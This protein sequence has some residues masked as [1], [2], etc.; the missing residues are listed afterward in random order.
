M[1][2]VTLVG[3]GPGHPDYLTLRGLR[4][5]DAADVI[6][7]D[8]LIDDSFKTLFPASAELFFV[9]K[10]CGQHYQTQEQI[11][12]LLVMQALQGNRIVR[13]KGGDPFLF[14]RGG[15][16]WLALTEAGV[17]VSVIPGVSSLNAAAALASIPLTHREVS[18]KVMFI[19]CHAGN[20]TR[21]D[22]EGIARFDG[23]LV[24][25]M[26]KKT[27]TDVACR[28]LEYKGRDGTP[29]ALIENASLPSQTITLSTLQA[30]ANYSGSPWKTDGPGLVY[31][32]NV[33]GLLQSSPNIPL[34]IQWLDHSATFSY[35]GTHHDF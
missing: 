25:F 28:I 33:V 21:Q 14:G 2:H 26:A 5:I 10:R 17:S 9:G 22:W 12:Q 13:L 24:L 20:L 15:E 34:R 8:A 31:I 3:A 1:G 30:L 11:N 35:G 29:V 23:T 18:G 4:E 19:E 6:V 27:I 32:G 7:Y 16:E